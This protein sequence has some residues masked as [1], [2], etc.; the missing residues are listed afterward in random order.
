M[1][2]KRCK[3]SIGKFIEILGDQTNITFYKINVSFKYKY[4]AHKFY[5]IKATENCTENYLQLE[6][7]IIKK[8]TIGN[9]F[10]LQYTN[11]QIF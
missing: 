11:K 6:L 1:E 7:I 4:V 2:I 3:K 10:S 5:I 9:G 8:I